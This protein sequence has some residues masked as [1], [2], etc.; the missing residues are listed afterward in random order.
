MSMAIDS[1]LSRTG[2][3]LRLFGAIQF[4]VDTAPQGPEEDRMRRDAL[5]DALSNCPEVVSSDAGMMALMSVHPRR[6]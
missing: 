2:W 3:I 4:D 1:E 6:F 5:C